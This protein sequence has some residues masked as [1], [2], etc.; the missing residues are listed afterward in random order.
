MQTLRQIDKH[1]IQVVP[2]LPRAPLQFRNK[3][4]VKM[5]PQNQLPLAVHIPLQLTGPCTFEL[6]HQHYIWCDRPT[7]NQLHFFHF[8]CALTLKDTQRSSPATFPKPEQV[9]VAQT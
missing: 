5:T 2:L 6:L 8:I 9:G 1:A 4:P 3:Q 7:S